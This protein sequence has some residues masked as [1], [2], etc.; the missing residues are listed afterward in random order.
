MSSTVEVVR[1]TI[2]LKKATAALI[3]ITGILISSCVGQTPVEIPESPTSPKTPTEL[4]VQQATKT[5]EVIITPTVGADRN[6]PTHF[7]GFYLGS[8]IENGQTKIIS[9]VDGNLF[10]SKNPGCTIPNID[11][12]RS[13]HNTLYNPTASNLPAAFMIPE[14]YL[15]SLFNASTDKSGGTKGSYGGSSV[16]FVDNVWKMENGQI[17]NPV[18]ASLAGH[19]FGYPVICEKNGQLMMSLVDDNGAIIDNT[20]RPA[21]QS[22]ADIA[23]DYGYTGTIKPASVGLKSDGRIEVKNTNGDIMANL[24]FLGPAETEITPENIKP[25]EVY[26]YTTGKT[27]TLSPIFDK[28]MNTWVWKNSIGEIRRFLDPETGHVFSQTASVGQHNQ[29]KNQRIIYQVDTDFGWEADLANID[30]LPRGVV[31][32]QYLVD[33]HDHFPEIINFANPQTTIT[34]KIISGHDDIADKNRISFSYKNSAIDTTI[35]Y[36]FPVYDKK[37]NTY[38]LTELFS[39]PPSIINQFTLLSITADMLNRCPTSSPP[40]KFP[41]GAVDVIIP[42]KPIQ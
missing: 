13:Q 42:K 20:L 26:N 17:F 4:P 3:P 14:S 32:L 41:I 15:I 28:D 33:I 27:E 8:Y 5:T 9:G 34:F 19:F 29:P 37:N 23:K 11:G 36:L 22:A 18:V 6:Y 10:E 38:V 21:F 1:P 40:E 30:K 7:D 39:A 31:G 12:H 16:E 24:K 2:S 35:F 25:M